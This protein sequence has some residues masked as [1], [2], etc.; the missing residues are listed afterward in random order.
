MRMFSFF[1]CFV[2]LTLAGCTSISTGNERLKS[3]SARDLHQEI[4]EGLTTQD[5]IRSMLGGPDQASFT[6]SGLAV[7]MY[8]FESMSQSAPFTP[9]FK[10]T[11]TLLIIL[12]NKNDR[13]QK[14]T[15]EKSEISRNVSWSLGI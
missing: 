10:G 13:V 6:D 12:F 9:R 11:K 7:W 15:Y 1:L 8:D 3:F 5:Q 14:F 2:M 4:V